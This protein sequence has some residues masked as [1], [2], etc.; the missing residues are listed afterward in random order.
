[1]KLRREGQTDNVERVVVQRKPNLPIVTDFVACVG[2]RAVDP[3]PPRLRVQAPTSKAVQ[4]GANRS[5]ICPGLRP[6]SD[7]PYVWIP[8][9]PGGWT[10]VR[11][12]C[13]W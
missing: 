5:R 1:M 3:A 7:S 11:I 6:N 4:Y 10:R 9:A 12:T 13:C 2:C 8:C